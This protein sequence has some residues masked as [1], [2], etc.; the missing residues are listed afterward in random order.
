MGELTKKNS[1]K[2]AAQTFG[3]CDDVTDAES[4]AHMMEGLV[5]RV[6][7]L[8]HVVTRARPD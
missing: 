3:L 1:N 4:L 2:S 7:P 5:A 8:V 6:T